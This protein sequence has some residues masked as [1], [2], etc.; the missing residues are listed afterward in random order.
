MKKIPLTKGKVALVSDRDYTWLALWKWW[1]MWNGRHWYAVRMVGGHNIY[2]HREIVGDDV[3]HVDHRD[4][5]GLNNQRRNLRRSNTSLNQANARRRIDNTSGYKGVS[6]VKR[7]NTWRAY[8]VV[9][10]KFISLGYHKTKTAAARAYDK[11][12]I[13][14]FGKHALLNF[15]QAA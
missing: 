4:R 15:H 9:N 12:A 13:K 1:A 7:D 8:I 2:M 11:A 6:Y 14:Y 3:T 5:N 10:R